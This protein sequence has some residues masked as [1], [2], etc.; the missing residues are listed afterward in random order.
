MRQHPTLA[1]LCDEL[2]RGGIVESEIRSPEYH[3]DGVCL[4]DGTIVL[5]QKPSYVLVALHELLH[6]MHPR[7]GE[8]RV[9]RESHYVLQRMSDD[10]VARFYRRSR[11]RATVRR[12]PVTA[13]QISG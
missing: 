3:I 6:R 1:D 13:I 10:D 9:E 12:R 8:A 4:E 11:R 2:R 5:N 7:W